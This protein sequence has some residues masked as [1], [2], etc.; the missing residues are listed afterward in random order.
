VQLDYAFTDW[1][2]AKFRVSNGLYQGPVDNNQGK[3][4]MGSINLTPTKDSWVNLIGFGGDGLAI[5]GLVENVD[6]ASAIGGYQVTSKLGTGFEA[7]YFHFD[8]Q[9]IASGDLWSLGGWVWYDFTSKVGVAFRA[10]YL[11]DKDGL[12]L[13]ATHGVAPSPFG[14]GIM[15]ADANGDLESFTFTVNLHPTPQLKIQPEIRYNH[16]S[17][18]AGFDGKRDQFIV[19]AGASYLF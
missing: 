15:S 11:D 5:P 17:Y 7:D 13:D 12:G 8:P 18:T 16:T 1:L 6:G 10:E 2:D 14:D 4:V 3:S 9:G 19:G